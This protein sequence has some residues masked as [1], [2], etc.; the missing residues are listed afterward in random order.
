MRSDIKLI[1]I[2]QAADFLATKESRIRYEI[3]HKKIPYIKLGKSIR[4]DE[5]DLIAW[6]LNQKQEVKSEPK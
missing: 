6:V 5:N 4:F 2:K 1:T 3:F